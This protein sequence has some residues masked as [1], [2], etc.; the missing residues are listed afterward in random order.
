MSCSLLDEIYDEVLNNLQNPG[1]KDWHYME[2]DRY[3]LDRRHTG[4]IGEYDF[5]LSGNVDNS[6]Y[7]GITLGLHDVHY[8]H[9]G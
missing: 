5:N 9:Y 6:F 7:W 4:Y 2:A 3:A 8:T 1:S